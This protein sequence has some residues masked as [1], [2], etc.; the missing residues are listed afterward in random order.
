MS[1]WV[2]D[3]DDYSRSLPVHIYATNMPGCA[4]GALCFVDGLVAN[5]ISTD[6]GVL[7]NCG[8]TPA[9]EF[10]IP[11]PNSLL[12]G[13]SHQVYFKPINYPAGNNNDLIG[14]GFVVP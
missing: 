1:G 7:A 6:P 10:S 8:G 2:C 12:Q 9:H 5:Q 11:M 13:G 3:R 4:S 14:D